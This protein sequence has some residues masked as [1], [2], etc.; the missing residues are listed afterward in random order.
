[1]VELGIGAGWYAEE[2]AAYGIPFPP[3]GERFDRLEES[4]RV[5]TGLWNTPEGQTLDLP[6]VHYPITGSPALPK[7][8]QRPHPPVITGGLGTKRTPALTA[9][10]AD[11]FNLPFVDT[12]TTAAAF[13]R[14][15]EACGAVGR[16][17]GEITLSNALVLCCGRD[18]A[19]VARRAGAIGRDGDELRANGLAGTPDE[20]VDTSGRYAELGGSGQAVGDRKSTRLNSSHVSISYAVFCLKTKSR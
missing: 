17:P 5:I 16:D 13:A 9:R 18:D 15:R 19:E 6:G 8:V 14:V 10:Y 20:L 11:E 7:P 3:L 4:L 12:E 2:H 1:R